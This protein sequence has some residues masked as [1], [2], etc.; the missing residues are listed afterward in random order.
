MYQNIYLKQINYNHYNV[1][2]WDDE[3]GHQVFEWRKTA[4]VPDPYGDYKSLDGTP[5]KKTTYF[6]DVPVKYESDVSPDTKL[7]VELYG[8]TDEPAK[9]QNRFYFDIEVSMEGQLPDPNEG[10]NPITSVAYY[11]ETTDEY[12]VYILDEFNEVE[13]RITDEYKLYRCDSEEELLDK[14]FSKWRECSPTIVTGW[15]IDFFDIPYLYNRAKRV[16]GTT[17]ANNLSPV[18]IVEYNTRKERYFIA[19]VSCLDYLPIYKNF[20]YTQLSSY[21]LDNVGEFELGQGKVEY[22]GT[23]DQLKKND[24]EK[25]IQYNL[26]DVKLIVDLEHKLKF[27]EQS[28]GI[29]SVGHVP[30]E[31]IY[32]SSR[33]LEGS[34]LCYLRRNG[35]RVANDKPP[36]TDIEST[37]MGAYVKEPKAGRYDYIF[38]LDL[39]SMYPSIIMSLNISPETKIGKVLDWNFK[40]YNSG[41]IKTIRVE[42]IDDGSVYEFDKEGFDSF[43]QDTKY[44]ISSNGI[45]YRTDVDGIIPKILRTWFDQRVEYKN[46]MKKYGNEGDDEQYQYFK[47]RQIIQKVL[48]NSIYGCLGL[49]GWR[50][51]DVDNALGVTSVGQEVIKFSSDMANHYYNKRLNQNDDWVIYTDTDSTFL[52]AVPIIKHENPDIDENDEELMCSLIADVAREVQDFINQSYNVMAKRMFNIHGSHRFEIKQENIARRGIWISKKR[53]VQ[54]IIWE[55]GVTK[56]DIDY[57][58]LDV[59]RSDFP[60]AF[61]SFMKGMLLDLLNGVEKDVVD[62]KL[63]EFKDSITKRPFMEVGKPTGVRGIKKYSVRGGL[64]DVKKGTPAHVKSAIYYNNFLKE[65]GLEDKSPPITD[66]EK[67]VWL[68]LKQNPLNLDIMALKGSDDPQEVV[69]FISTYADYDKMFDRLLRKKILDFYEALDW[70]SFENINLKANQFFSF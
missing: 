1:H 55:N 32:Q 58:G 41:E 26:V 24:I 60:K 33:F 70:E 63:L 34:I 10:N 53:Y 54:K 47:S 12:G 6:H 28:V 20:T 15:N 59:V 5:C 64:S 66:G 44:S 11:D 49:K 67:I 7:L 30:Y 25:F 68:Y 13:N 40:Q 61:K 65:R 36:R 37:F 38:D 17:F 23:L 51:Y 69:D 56:D 35:N 19:G 29:T 14:F 50:W 18:G 46:L 42:I 27:L 22:E 39:T 16:M 8:E 2:L 21:R 45:L 62:K 52:S 9:W 48:L 43:L 57:K 4:F 3:K 31:N